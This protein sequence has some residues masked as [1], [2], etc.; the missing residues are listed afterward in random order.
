MC[1]RHLLIEHSPNTH[2]SVSDQHEGHNSDL[3]LAFMQPKSMSSSCSSYAGQVQLAAER[4]TGS[5]R[6]VISMAGNDG[7]GDSA[8]GTLRAVSFLDTV[9]DLW[10]QLSYA[11]N[12]I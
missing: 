7:E 2:Y 11:T 5:K 1:L 10:G 8:A 12:R 9:S 6:K 3:R 4:E